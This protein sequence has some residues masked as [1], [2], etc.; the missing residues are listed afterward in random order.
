MHSI[1]YTPEDSLVFGGNFLHSYGVPAQLRV[2]EIEITTHVPKKFRFPYFCKLCWYVADHFLHALKA[3]EEFPPRVLA[4]IYALANFLVGEARVM[5][6]S[7][8]RGAGAEAAKKEAR[9]QVP[10][11]KVRDASALAREL[12]WRVNLALNGESGDEGGSGASNSNG[13]ISK[14]KGVKRR[15][16]ETPD[17]EGFGLSVRFRNFRPKVWDAQESSSKEESMELL[18]SHGPPEG[19]GIEWTKHWLGENTILKEEDGDGM[20][21]DGENMRAKVRKVDSVLSRVRRTPVGLERQHI[22]RKVEYW[23]WNA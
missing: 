18:S 22:I 4:S 16:S 23:E 1:Q 11:E 5:E 19:E 17:A 3:K 9:D 7:A 10:G 6:R 2:R 13:G 14:E 15:L 21:V 12:R 8:G 20:A